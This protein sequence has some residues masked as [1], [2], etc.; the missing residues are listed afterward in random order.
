VKNKEQLPGCLPAGCDLDATLTKPQAA[1][2]L[3]MSE[4]KLAGLVHANL[5][6]AITF[7]RKNWRFHPRTCLEFW[8]KGKTR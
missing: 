7:D 5:I 3:Q 2:W 6:P 1:I 8:K 4:E